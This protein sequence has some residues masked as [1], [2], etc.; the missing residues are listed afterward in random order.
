MKPHNVIIECVKKE[1]KASKCENGGHITDIKKKL[2][3]E[4]IY[5]RSVNFERFNTLI[6]GNLYKFVE[7]R[8]DVIQWEQLN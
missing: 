2:Y 8:R 5:R 6:L 4:T 3:T 7:Q 1:Y